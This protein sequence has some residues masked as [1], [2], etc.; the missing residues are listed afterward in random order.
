MMTLMLIFDF[1]FKNE[2]RKLRM[3][4]QYSYWITTLLRCCRYFSCNWFNMGV[5]WFIVHT[6]SILFVRK[7]NVRDKTSVSHA[8]TGFGIRCYVAI[9]FIL[10]FLFFASVHFCLSRGMLTVHT[11]CDLSTWFIHTNTHLYFIFFFFA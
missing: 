8:S 1:R 7:K 2:L 6:Y 4:S 3:E 11:L 10:F 5:V 9:L